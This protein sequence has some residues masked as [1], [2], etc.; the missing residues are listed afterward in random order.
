MLQQ[1][2]TDRG[3]DVEEIPVAILGQQREPDEVGEEGHDYDEDTESE[4]ED[5]GDD[6]MDAEYNE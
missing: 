5:G 3:L 4:D 1:I 2:Y 6:D